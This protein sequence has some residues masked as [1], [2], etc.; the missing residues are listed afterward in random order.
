[1]QAASPCITTYTGGCGPKFARARTITTRRFVMSEGKKPGPLEGLSDKEKLSRYATL[2]RFETEEDIDVLKLTDQW[3]VDKMGVIGMISQAKRNRKLYDRLI[4]QGYSDDEFPV[5]WYSPAREQASDIVQ[6]T[7]ANVEKRPASPN[8]VPSRT[9]DDVLTPQLPKEPAPGEGVPASPVLQRRDDTVQYDT[10]LD[11]DGQGF[12]QAEINLLGANK[13][14]RGEDGVWKHIEKEPSGRTI[15]TPVNPMAEL[16]RLSSQAQGDAILQNV[17]KHM[18]EQLEIST[19]AIIKKV[20]LNPTVFWLFQYVT[21]IRDKD[22]GL[23][24]FVGD[25]G[26]FLSFCARFTG[27]AYYGVVPTYVTNRPSFLTTLNQQQQR[28]TYADQP[29]LTYNQLQSARREEERTQ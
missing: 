13:I 8:G 5:W 24:L 14:V 10:G 27:E 7:L 6:E 9:V 2:F 19:Q 29:Q 20:A 3:N 15:I 26:D 11:D 4:V 18:I 22:T 12:T 28:S 17:N 25:I 16:Q 23:P 21:S 1:M